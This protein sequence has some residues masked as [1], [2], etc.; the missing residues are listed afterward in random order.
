MYHNNLKI[1]FRSLLRRRTFTVINT[2]G[3]TLGMTAAIFK[4][5]LILPLNYL[6]SFPN[7]KE[8]AKKWDNFNFLTFVDWQ[9]IRNPQNIQPC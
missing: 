4:H 6:F 2:I 3:L 7:K 8:Q 9:L 1:A 5:E